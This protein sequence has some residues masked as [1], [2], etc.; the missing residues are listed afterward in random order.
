MPVGGP[1]DPLQQRPQLRLFVGG[2][3][4]QQLRLRLAQAFASFLERLRAAFRD[5]HPT[6]PAVDG[7]LPADQQAL[8][9]E[10]VEQVGH[11]RLV[12]IPYMASKAALSMMTVQY[13]KAYPGLRINVV[14]P[15]PTATGMN[16]LPGVQPVEAGAAPIV[17]AARFT[18]ADPTG[19]FLD[20]D[21]VSPW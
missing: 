10:I 15:G 12:E 21:G 6:C 20:A 11:H 14:D 18:P 2:Q 5:E 4:G 1:R 3:V 16:S 17:R 9:F 19:A 7:I 13:A 8:G